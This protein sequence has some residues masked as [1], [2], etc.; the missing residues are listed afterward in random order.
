MASGIDGY[1]AKGQQLI[2]LIPCEMI[3]VERNRNG[4]RKHKIDSQQ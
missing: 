4:E 2:F 1:R 3:A